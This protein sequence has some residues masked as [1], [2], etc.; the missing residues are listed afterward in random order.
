MNQIPDSAKYYAGRENNDDE[1][2]ARQLEIPPQA[3]MKYMENNP[4][5]RYGEFTTLPEGSG[6]GLKPEDASKKALAK[7]ELNLLAKLIGADAV[8]VDCKD[9]FRI[10]LFDPEPEEVL[11]VA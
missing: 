4:V 2:L 7:E 3:G 5:S 1:A 8:D 10:N 9:A 6:A 11:E